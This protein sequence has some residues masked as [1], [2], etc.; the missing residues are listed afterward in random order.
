MEAP[1]RRWKSSVAAGFVHD[2]RASAV[3]PQRRLLHRVSGRSNLVGLQQRA[4]KVRND[5]VL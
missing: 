4:R 1:D 2:W 5:F 3:S